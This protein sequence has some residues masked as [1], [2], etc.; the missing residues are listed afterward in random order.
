LKNDVN[1]ASK[2]KKQ[3]NFFLSVFVDLLKV[4]DE[5]RR[6]R[7]RIRIRNVAVPPVKDTEEHVYLRPSGSLD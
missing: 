3:K 7:I 5:N 2:S 4:N 6:I 1:V